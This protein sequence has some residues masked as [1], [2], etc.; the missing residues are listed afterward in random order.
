MLASGLWRGAY[1]GPLHPGDTVENS[2]TLW[3]DFCD[4]QP[5]ADRAV[6]RP[7][8]SRSGWWWRGVLRVLR[9]L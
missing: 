4:D 7:C 6:H 5:D 2:F 8:R 9:L 3:A 1:T